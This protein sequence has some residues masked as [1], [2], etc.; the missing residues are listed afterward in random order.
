MEINI[1]FVQNEIAS[2]VIEKAI[3]NV[4]LEW[5][6]ARMRLCDFFSR[7][8]FRKEKLQLVPNCAKSV[9]TEVS[10]VSL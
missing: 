8:L 9:M 7:T 4:S 5:A 3:E 10:A 1:T 6:E 2:K